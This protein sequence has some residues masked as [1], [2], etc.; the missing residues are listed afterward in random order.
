MERLPGH[1]K[2][3]YEVE[4]V[5]EDLVAQNFE[6]IYNGEEITNDAW[7]KIWEELYEKYNLN[8]IQKNDP[9]YNIKQEKSK[10]IDIC[11][12]E[13]IFEKSQ[14]ELGPSQVYR[15]VKQYHKLPSQLPNEWRN[16]EPEIRKQIIKEQENLD[17]NFEKMMKILEAKY[18]K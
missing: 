3:K 14:H 8:N 18:S 17:E 11:M 5:L 7:F 12:E 2:W 15:F 13:Y 1:D 6:E 16:F 4:N 10:Y 9:E